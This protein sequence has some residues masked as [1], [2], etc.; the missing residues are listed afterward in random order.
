VSK[1]ERDEKVEEEKNE[2]AMAMV[3]AM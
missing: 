3:M 1:T 2:M